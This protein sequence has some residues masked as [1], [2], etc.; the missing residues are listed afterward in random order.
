LAALESA[1]Q[2]ASDGSR[3]ALP[4]IIEA[5]RRGDDEL[6][7]VIIAAGAKLET[8][9][10]DGNS[11]LHRAAE[12]GHVE[13]VR[14]LLR[15]GVDADLRGENETTALMHGMASNAEHSDR[16]VEELLAAGADPHS[17]DRMAAGMIH[18]AAKG[19]TSRKLELLSQ[20]GG[21]WTDRDLE[22]SLERA[23]RA[24]R[25]SV[26]RAL[27]HVTPKMDSRIPALCSVIGTDQKKMLG[28]LLEGNPP[29]DLPC[30]DGSTALMIAAQLD[31]SEIIST[32]LNA[33]ANPNQ[34]T[35]SGDN[36]L[37]AAAS[38][39]HE[40]IV[41]RLLRSG[42]EV[43]RRGGHRMTALMGAASNGKA[44][45]VLVLLEAGADRRMRCDT[46][47]TALKLAEGAGHQE[48]AQ[49]IKSQ[50]AGWQAWFGARQ[51]PASR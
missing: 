13:V 39:G 42:A 6:L 36:P 40:E 29:L 47:D 45:V 49:M 51:S 43:D 50:K 28:L 25:S 44:K 23:A 15:A 8:S 31:R 33:G 34:N 16:V 27:L 3:T 22:R 12:G 5:A 17:R 38:R 26:V 1:S 35:R 2:Q 30:A 7:R 37:I 14:S 10:P 19:A 41:V 20:A 46:G 48:I 4:P 11:A 24:E 9:D 18:Y 21:S 32:L